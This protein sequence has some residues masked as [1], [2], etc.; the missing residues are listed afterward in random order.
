VLL[1]QVEKWKCT[2]Y[3]TQ[4]NKLWFIFLIISKHLLFSID[5]EFL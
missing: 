5:S 2:S 4:R 3:E 1:P